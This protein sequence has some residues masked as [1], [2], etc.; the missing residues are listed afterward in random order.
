MQISPLNLIP[1]LIYSDETLH[2]ATEGLKQFNR[3][4][5]NQHPNIALSYES[6]SEMQEHK[7]LKDCNCNLIQP[8]PTDD[9]DSQF[10]DTALDKLY[11]TLTNK[12]STIHEEIHLKSPTKLI[13]LDLE[14]TGLNKTIKREGGSNRIYNHIVGVCIGL[15]TKTG[16]YLPVMHNQLDKVPNFTLPTILAF[17]QALVDNFHIIYHNAVFDQEV[18][19]L[20]GVRFPHELT[21]SDTMLMAILSGYRIQY[22]QV[23]LKFL[24][25]ELLHRNML[26]INELLGD[27]S[28][29][30]MLNLA[31]ASNCYVYGCS[32]AINT[33]A[34][35]KHI[36]KK[37]NPY[38]EQKNATILDHKSV[39]VVRS[40]FRV[41]LPVHYES[42][43][44][45]LRTLMRRSIMLENIFYSICTAEQ[46]EITSAEQI[47]THIYTLLKSEFEKK[48]NNGE[49]LDSESKGFT[50]L[51]KRLKEHFNMEVKVKT[52]K[53][54]KRIVANSGADILD[55]LTDN[56]NKWDFIAE[57]TAN[58][59]YLICDAVKYFRKLQHEIAIFYRL[60]RFCYNDELNLCRAGIG[61][62]LSGADTSR[63]SNQGSLE[64]SFDNILMQQ[65][66]TKMK[67]TLKRGNGICGVNAQGLSNS[68][69]KWV[70]A[71]RV[72]N[73]TKLDPELARIHQRLNTMTEARI[74][75]LFSTGKDAG[76]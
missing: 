61:L 28:K 33:Y 9:P 63:F 27:K 57:P 73:F 26:E 60:T 10:K 25:K 56:L 31:P 48:Y 19:A 74:R 69:G 18:M 6:L 66:P 34:L 44:A 49:P 2:H 4:H 5:P 50:I 7:W 47:G 24:S 38:Q 42:A 11:Q 22:R 55:L 13:S 17:L 16:Y 62:R 67:T 36:L 21:F 35:F 37:R 3:E 45:T 39:A 72:K 58:E 14:T 29:E 41:G 40:L 32:D 15:D 76:E 1:P 59:I 64:G 68:S 43:L 23:G 70:K 54:G 8:D 51:C 20:N 30:V 65:L 46:I 75:T 53:T 12:A 71:K 52:L